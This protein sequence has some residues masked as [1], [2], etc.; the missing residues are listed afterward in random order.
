[1]IAGGFIIAASLAGLMKLQSEVAAYVV[2]FVGAGFG[3]F[4]AGRA[5]P[6]KTIIEPAVAG[7]LLVAS[8]VGLIVLVPGAR[9]I[10]SI[11]GDQAKQEVLIRALLVGGLTG[12]GGL[13]GAVLGERTQPPQSDSA[14]RWIGVSSLITLGMLFFLFSVLAIL[15][16]R[17]A[18]AG[19]SITDDQGVGVVFLALAGS[20]LLGGLTTQAIAPRRMCFA[21]GSGFLVVLLAMLGVGVSQAEGSINSQALTG[22]VI[23][24]LGGMLVGA[25]GALIGW[26]LIGKRR[27]AAA[28]PTEVARTF[29]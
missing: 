20:A 4:F 27:V 18:A 24:A 22:M 25:L 5:S 1:M 10:W 21:C 14:M 28:Q 11:A 13:V 17:H 26:A 12:A 16:L 8:F 23:I 15:M 7:F 19:G 6:G 2:Y 9:E 3:G 29:E